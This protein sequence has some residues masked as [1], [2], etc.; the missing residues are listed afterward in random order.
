MGIGKYSTSWRKNSTKVFCT[1]CQKPESAKIRWKFSRPV[2]GLCEHRDEAV[3]AEI[4]VVVL[5]GDD[6]AEDRY[7]VEEEYQRDRGQGHQ[8]Q[9]AVASEPQPEAQLS[10]VL[11]GAPPG[12]PWSARPA[13]PSG[14]PPSGLLLPALAPALLRGTVLWDTAFSLPQ[15][16]VTWPRSR[17]RRAA[18]CTRRAGRR[19]PS[20]SSPRRPAACRRSSCGRGRCRPPAARSRWRGWSTGWA[21]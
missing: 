4:R 6:V 15:S 19:R 1:A 16:W 7:V 18:S 14:G 2:Q 8:D 3:V 17:C 10:G 5:E 11:S 9:G 13:A 21:R 20:A 12:P